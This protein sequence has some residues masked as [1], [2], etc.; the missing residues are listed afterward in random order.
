M[1]QAEFNLDQPEL[2]HIGIFLVLSLFFFSYG[3][4]ALNGYGNH[5]DIYRML[6]TWRTLVTEHRYAASRFQGYLVPEMTIGLA[7]ELGGSF[8]SN[9]VS[10]T[11]AVS[12]LGL[13]YLL[14]LPITTP[15]FATLAVVAVGSNPYWIIP[16]T[17]STDYIY[18]I[19]FFILGVFLLVQQKMRWAGLIFALAVSSRITYAPLGLLAFV[20]YLPL[21]RENS[22]LKSLIFQ[23][24]VVLFLGSIA[25]YL[26]VFFAS[27]MSLSFLKYANDAAGGTLGMIVRFVYKNIY[28]WGIPAFLLLSLF[29][30]KERSFYWKQICTNPLRNLRREHLVFQA[31]FG[32]FL[33]T[34]FWFA[35]L[36][37]QYQ[38][39]LPLLFCITYFILLLPN[40]RKRL[41]CLS[42]IILFHLAHSLL[43]NFDLLETYQTGNDSFK[44]IH[45]DGAK[46]HPHLDAG[47]LVKDFDR[48]SIY[49]SYQLEEFNKRWA[50]YKSLHD[51]WQSPPVQ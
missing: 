27:G 36:P 14:L 28:F 7:S 21:V 37:H 16:A 8:L 26:P 41:V 31:V 25:L 5:D 50:N 12:S 38:Y 30:I 18:P 45:A 2:K 24:I 4:Y 35:K 49:Q 48:R 42:L 20:F 15:L 29:F 1:A 9:L 34:E 23:G 17:T 10:V 44:T 43:L 33:Y 11:L 46:F 22:R 3:L 39:L 19:F 40:P 32:L 47:V 51:R 6:S 13:F